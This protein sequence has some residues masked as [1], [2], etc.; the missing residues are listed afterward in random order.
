M[1]SLSSFVGFNIAESVAL[2]VVNFSQNYLCLA[3][4]IVKYT[5]FPQI[6]TLLRYFLLLWVLRMAVDDKE[7]RGA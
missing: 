4:T 7:D 3:F 2:V 5:V 6:E 1:V